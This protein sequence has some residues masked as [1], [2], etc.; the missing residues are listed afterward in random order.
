MNI[1]PAELL[2]VS[3]VLGVLPIVGIIDAALRPDDVWAR[4]NQNKLVWIVVQ[5]VLSVVGT[6][7]YFIAVRPKLKAAA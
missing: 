5:I 4:A 7:A 1:G 2:I 3:V 6:L